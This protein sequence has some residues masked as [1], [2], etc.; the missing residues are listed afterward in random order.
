VAN[1]DMLA[2]F[3]ARNNAALQTLVTEHGVEL[4]QFPDEVLIKLKGFSDEVVAEVAE[5]DPMSKKVYESFR[6]FRDQAIAWHNV[7]ERAYLN[8]RSL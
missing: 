5:K 7:S 8:A 1:L 3:T 2:D 6:K 4:R